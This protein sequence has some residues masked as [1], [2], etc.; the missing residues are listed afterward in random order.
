M[1]PAVVEVGGSSCLVGS[2]VVKMVCQVVGAL[3]VMTK[4]THIIHQLNSNSA[5]TLS[6]MMQALKKLLHDDQSV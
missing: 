2:A 1:L 6:I 3:G 4:I 5:A